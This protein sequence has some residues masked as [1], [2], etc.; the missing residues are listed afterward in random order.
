M[1]NFFIVIMLQPGKKLLLQRVSVDFIAALLE[2]LAREEFCENDLNLIPKSAVIT[3]HPD[4][5]QIENYMLYRGPAVETT[6]EVLLG[7]T[8]NVVVTIDENDENTVK[9]EST[10]SEETWKGEQ[11]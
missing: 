2:Y 9:S 1:V 8:I 5:L 7:G 11:M 6:D 4:W 3:I 10:E